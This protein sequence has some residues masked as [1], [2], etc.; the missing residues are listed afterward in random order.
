MAQNRSGAA[1]GFTMFAGIMMILIGSFHI[2]GGL[3][4]IFSDTAYV[5]TQKWILQFDTTTWG[6]IHLLAGILILLAGFGV[7]SGAVW[8]RTVGVILATISA[9]AN[10]AW[11]PYQPFWSITMIVVDIF[12][13]WALTVHGRDIAQDMAP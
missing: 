5:V 9:I 2:I 8:A 11:L 13:I 6:W 3:G 10:F 12:V 4:G 7:Y 1:V